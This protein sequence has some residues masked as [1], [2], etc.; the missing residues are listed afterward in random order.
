[1]EK[2]IS[3]ILG[4]L[5]GTALTTVTIPMYAKTVTTTIKDTSVVKQSPSLDEDTVEITEEMAKTINEVAAPEEFTNNVITGRA[6]FPAQPKQVAN[7]IKGMN[8]QPARPA[9]VPVQA[10]MRQPAVTTT[11]GVREPHLVT[12]LN[13]HTRATT[14]TTA[15]SVAQV[16]TPVAHVSQIA[17]HATMARATI[18]VPMAVRTHEAIRT[19]E[20][21]P[22]VPTKGWAIQMGAFRVKSNA[23]RL[24][25][26]LRSSGYNAFSRNSGSLTLVFVGP[27]MKRASAHELSSKVTSDINMKGIIVHV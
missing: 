11:S 26:K 1:M 2:N 12:T 23:T 22:S 8:V 6:G 21:A 7:T 9:P 3:R 16:V 19:E 18:P 20:A 17:P 14:T 24:L 27:E 4:V 5:V 25:D 15:T 13:T 10:G